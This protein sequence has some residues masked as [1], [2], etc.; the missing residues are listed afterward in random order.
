MI[1]QYTVVIRVVGTKCFGKTG[2][3]QYCFWWEGWDQGTR[4]IRLPHPSQRPVLHTC[5]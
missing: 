5:D 4:L 1:S 3:H 2:R